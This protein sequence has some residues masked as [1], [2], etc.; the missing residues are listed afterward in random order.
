MRSIKWFDG[1]HPAVARLLAL[2]AWGVAL[3][4]ISI[5]VWFKPGAH[6][7]FTA[8]REAGAHWVNT[9]ELYF[10]GSK[11]LYSPLAAAWFAPF[12]FLSENVAGITWRLLSGILLVV[13]VYTAA[14]IVWS[15]P[16]SRKGSWA[17][18]ALLP[19]SLSNLNNGQAN[20]LVLGLIV[21]SVVALLKEHWFLCSLC[22][23]IASYFKIYPVALGLLLSTIFLRHLSWRLL[24]AIVGLFVVSL[25][26]QRPSYVLGQ[27][28]S[29]F[30]HLGG[31]TRRSADESRAWRDA[32][33]LLRM[34][35][36]PITPGAWILVEAFAGITIAAFCVWGIYHSWQKQRMI[37]AAFALGCVWMVLFGPATEA[38]SY[39]LLGPSIIYG[40][41]ESWRSIAPKWTRVGMTAAYSGLLLAD[42][43]DSWLRLKGQTV[44]ARAFQPIVAVIF[45][46]TLVAWLA[47]DKYWRASQVD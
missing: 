31:I 14:Q 25:L 5:R 16:G 23:A 17:L 43:S 11:F 8:F 28:A 29:W 47:T 45:F 12:S 38:A 32:Y 6:S 35:G 37:Y 15:Q 30:E 36:I 41:F 26:M 2:G 18:V 19:L 22:L 1:V 7:V 27:Y 3:V 39:M 9:G 20:P 40:L 42:I 44:Y 46:V 4:I 10:H 13:A 21:F 24:L 33:F 34:V